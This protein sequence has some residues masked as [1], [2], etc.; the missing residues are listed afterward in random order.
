MALIEY[1]IYESSIGTLSLIAKDGRLVALKMTQEDEYRLARL[2]NVRYPQAART[3]KPF[4]R[5]RLLLDRYLR[6]QKVDFDIPV[7]VSAETPFTQKV[8]RVLQ[9]I[10]Y[11]EVRSYLWVGKQLGYEIAAQAVGQAVKRNPIPIIIPCHRVIR[12][13]GT[14]GGFSSGVNMKRRFL[15]IEKVE[16]PRPHR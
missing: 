2:M 8:L 4:N 12:E 6:G 5:V 13:D 11:G 3:G 7:D 15:A 9:G 1:D 14:I 10:P 16:L